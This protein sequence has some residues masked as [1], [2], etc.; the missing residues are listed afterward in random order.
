MNLNVPRFHGDI[1]DV[2]TLIQGTDDAFL[3]QQFVLAGMPDIDTHGTD[4]VRHLRRMADANIRLK[5]ENAYV[6]NNR[7]FQKVSKEFFR[8][9]KAT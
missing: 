3:L 5:Q 7:T 1:S 9:D 6:S 2:D 4:A 8:E